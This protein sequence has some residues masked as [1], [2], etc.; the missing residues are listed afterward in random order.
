MKRLALLGLLLLGIAAR[1]WAASWG[2]TYD[3]ESY[4]IVARVVNDGGNVYAQTTRYNYGPFW[5]IVLGLLFRVA[6]WFPQS[7]PVFRYSIVAA[8]SAVDIGVYY[9]LKSHFSV[10]AGF[11]YFLNPISIIITGYYSQ[12]D[13]VP[14]LLGLY[15]VAL[16]GKDEATIRTKQKIYSLVVLGLS[17]IAKHVLFVL[18][19]WIAVRQKKFADKAIALLLPVAIFFI[20]FM[21]FAKRGFSGIVNNVFYYISFHNAPLWNIL[22]PD[23]LKPIVNPYTFFL[24]ALIAG[25]FIFRKKKPLDALLYYGIVLVLFSIA[26]SEQYFVSAL[27]FMSVYFN[28][29]FA[30]FSLVQM[31]FM[32]LMTVE[33]EIYVPLLGM[34]VD[35]AGFGFGTQMVLL[36]LGFL[37]TLSYASVRKFS[38][39]QWIGALILLLLSFLA[40]N[41]FPNKLEDRKVAAIESAIST[42][43][44]EAANTLYGDIEKKPPFAGSRFW[45]KLTRSRYYIEYYRNYRK[46]SDITSDG[47][48][49]NEKSKIPLLLKGIPPDFPYKEEVKGM[50]ESANDQK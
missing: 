24:V 31:L 16:Y 11:L 18:P 46:A 37:F 25:A 41:V 47:L 35:R 10:K 27:P 49:V 20:S 6:Q 13:A 8:L 28:P 1:F 48:T 2:H 33:G 14:L 3:L 5:F 21:P 22:M 42:G 36:F 9:F 32:L 40:F 29:F 34:T 17:L 12:F 45:N 44:Y 15:A 39:K 4:E 38:P 19:L 7:F 43:D 50:L 26:M 30:L 23:S